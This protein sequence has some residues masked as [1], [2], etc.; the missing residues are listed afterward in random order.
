M[1][2]AKVMK[3]RP[4]GLLAVERLVDLRIPRAVVFAQVD[5][6]RHVRPEPVADGDQGALDDADVPSDRV[7]IS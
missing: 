2:T 7:E 4:S 6:A 5:I 1:K 3:T